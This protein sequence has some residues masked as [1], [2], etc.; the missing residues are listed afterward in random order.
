MAELRVTYDPVAKAAYVS[1]SSAAVSH[2]REL[3]PDSVWGDFDADGGL[4]GVETIDLEA[5]DLPSLLKAIEQVF[6]STPLD[7]DL[8]QIA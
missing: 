3:V 8:L 6:S 2:T 7:E 1:V 4:V 5:H